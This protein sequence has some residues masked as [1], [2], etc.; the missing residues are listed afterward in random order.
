MGVAARRGLANHRTTADALPCFVDPKS[1]AL[2]EELG[3][4][5]E[6]EVRSRYEVKLE[7]YNKLL[8]IE[9]RTMKRMVRRAYLPAINGYAAEV[10]RGIT[11]V[12]AAAAGVEVGQQEALLRKLFAGVKE[13]D[14]QLQALDAAHHAALELV[15]QQQR[16]NKYAHEIVPIMEKLRAAVDEMEIVTDRDHWPVPTYN[17]M[18]FYV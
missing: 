18:L 6:A 13:I 8:N 7:K 12:R 17:D 5:S 10:A 16:A 15:D 1:I 14:A 9:A 11:A 4:L 2:F 3:V